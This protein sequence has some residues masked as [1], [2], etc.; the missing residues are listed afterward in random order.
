[1]AAMMKMEDEDEDG[2]EAKEPPPEEP[3]EEEE[4]EESEEESESESESESDNESVNEAE[5][6]LVT[7][8]RLVTIKYLKIGTLETTYLKIR[9]QKRLARNTIEIIIII[10]QK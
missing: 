6:C 4:E 2:E 8:A 9:D 7:M 5:V 1:M 10:L 3:E